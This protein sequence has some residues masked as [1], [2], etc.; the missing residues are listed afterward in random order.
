MFKFDQITPNL[1]IYLSFVFFLI[2]LRATF[3]LNVTIC[4]IFGVKNIPIVIS[5]SII[6]RNY[7][8]FH[9]SIFVV[10][11]FCT[12]IHVNLL[13]T[14]F[15]FWIETEIQISVWKWSLISYAVHTSW[16]FVFHHEIECRIYCYVWTIPRWEQIE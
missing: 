2:F 9:T 10:L 13:L 16:W 7:S 14:L 3:L 12:F 15:L 11:V 4:I 5:R 1:F 6:G 8:L